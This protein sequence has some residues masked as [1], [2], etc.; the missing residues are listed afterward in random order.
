MAYSL[1][2]YDR[3]AN[4]ITDFTP[5]AYRKVLT[6]HATDWMR[7]VR[8][9]G[10][11]FTG[12]FTV[13]P[14]TMSR[15]EMINFY[16]TGIGMRVVERTA[17]IV[18]WEGEIVQ[19]DLMLD[20]LGY[21]LSLDPE[22]W[23][24]KVKVKYGYSATAWSETTASSDI[25]G[26][27]NYIDYLGG[28]YDS[29]SATARQKRRLV[30]NSY[31]R[32]RPSGGLT[33]GSLFFPQAN[34]LH[35]VCAGYV[36]GMNRRFQTSDIAATNISDQIST[37]VGN[38]EF[39]TAGRIDANTLSV[40]VS[41]AGIEVRLWDLIQEL[42]EMGDDTDTGNRWVGGVYAGREFHYKQAE[43]TVTH[44]WRNGRL[45]HRGAPMLPTNVLPDII[46]RVPNAPHNSLAPVGY[47][48][49]DPKDL[50]IE[51]VEFIAPDSYRLIPYG[52]A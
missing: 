20:G 2:L 24:N 52:V 44:F 4:P 12:D 7:T 41:V 49:D 15:Q 50:Y 23:H 29:A 16:E 8:A 30:E 11:Y 13:T 48:W 34:S 45:E 10:G 9:A 32:S 26:E 37:L 22:L 3:I 28:A 42:I 1:F 5:D 6:N 31:P 14:Q 21:R 38:S 47:E 27:S 35:V 33:S 39:V 43:T 18:T 51:E 25:Y 17:G 46:V 40:P 36:L 19:L